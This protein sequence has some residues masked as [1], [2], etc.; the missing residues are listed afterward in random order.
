MYSVRQTYYYGS[1]LR[2]EGACVA[3]GAYQ[4]AAHTFGAL[5]AIYADTELLHIDNSSLLVAFLRA[6]LVMP[7]PHKGY[8][9]LCRVKHN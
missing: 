9:F 5:V 6:M 4:L 1:S 2:V 3:K 8:H 7:C